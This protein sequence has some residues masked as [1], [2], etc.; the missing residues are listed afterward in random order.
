M[1]K[2]RIIALIDMD[3]FYVQVEQRLQPRLYGK[4]VAVVQHSSVNHKGGGLLA[5]SYEARQFGIKRGM[6][7]DEA[8]IIC[9]ELELC[10]VPSGEH[11]DKA[12]ITRY[13]DASAEVF[14]VL[15]EFDARIVV[16]RASVDEAYLDL[17]SIVNQTFESIH[18]SSKYGKSD[19][20]DLF[21]T[22]H[23]ANGT[24]LNE[25]GLS[26]WK[27]DRIESLRLF[28]HHACETKDEY[29]LKLIIGANLIEQ[30]RSQIKRDTKFSCSAGIGSSKMI[31]KLVCSRHKPGQQ[32]VIYD[33]AITE[34]F[35]YTPI[36]EVRNLGGKL[37]RQLMKKFNIKTMGELSQIS[38]LDL[39]ECF[40]AQ[41]KWIHNIARGVDDEKVNAR[42]K[43]SS[44]AV[45]KNFPGSNALKTDGDVKFWL[46]GLIK[47]L[48]KRLTDDQ[49]KGGLR[50]IVF[51][52]NRTASTLHIGCTTDAH[53]TRSMQI[54]TYEP[55]A[56][57]TSVWPILRHI[58]KSSILGT[59][60]P[61]VKNISLSADR[62]REGIDSRS[63]QITEWVTKAVDKTISGVVVNTSSLRMGN[64]KRTVEAIS[65]KISPIA[66]DMISRCESFSKNYTARR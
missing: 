58:N 21:P 14:K 30:I 5:V 36:C 65:N 34:I 25:Q 47:E 7:G 22:T 57:F 1:D 8:K 56:L 59:W 62:F 15:H 26:G 9:P 32:S 42:D 24:D 46:D 54:K 35:K 49:L 50:S 6:F 12:D 37:G 23:V 18:P 39:V 66:V 40:S 17:T 44:V 19:A 3:C 52:N 38:M 4:P 10:F 43:Q 41:A 55:Q 31:A 11:I 13:R 16:E 45:S 29:K 53:V 51:Q 60:N 2:K 61:T 63:K 28:I 48:V 27:Y 33:E 64:S 20:V